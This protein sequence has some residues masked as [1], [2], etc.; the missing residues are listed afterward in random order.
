MSERFYEVPGS[1]DGTL[2]IVN[3]HNRAQFSVFESLGNTEVR[4][5]FPV[6][7]DLLAKVRRNLGKRVT[8][9][10]MVRYRTATDAP[11][12]I[13]VED[14]YELDGDDEPLTFE[15]MPVI[16]LAPGESSEA[17]IRRMRDE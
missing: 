16:D 2:E 5:R 13:T 17:Y 3:V 12:S 10:G 8:V 6:S 11:V 4:C 14:I 9:L 1:V 15:R 7:D